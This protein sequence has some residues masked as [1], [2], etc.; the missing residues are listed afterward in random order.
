M[1][2]LP[3]VMCRRTLRFSVLLDIPIWIYEHKKL[4]FYLPI[5]IPYL[6]YISRIGIPIQN[7]VVTLVYRSK[8]RAA[9]PRQQAAT[10]DD[11]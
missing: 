11:N 8:L 5:W 10:G 9:E 2:T 3:N 7:G 6:V 4:L 1:Q